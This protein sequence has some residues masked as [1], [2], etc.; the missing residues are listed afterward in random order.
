MR[1]G[2]PG[3]AADSAA[4]AASNAALPSLTS[5]QAAETPICASSLRSWALM[6]SL[7]GYGWASTHAASSL[8]DLAFRHL[9]HAAS[10]ALRRS[11]TWRAA[12]RGKA[13]WERRAGASPICLLPPAAAKENA[14][15]Q[16]PP[17]GLKCLP[18]MQHIKLRD[19]G[20]APPAY[21]CAGNVTKIWSR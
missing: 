11:A 3:R 16:G 20:C 13:G 9:A 1:E 10:T 19:D 8:S 21:L 18:A 4:I 12:A 6:I 17:P 7:T 5:L 14:L 2:L 15:T